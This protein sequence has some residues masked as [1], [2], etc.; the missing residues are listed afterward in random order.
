MKQLQLKRNAIIYPNRADA[1]SYINTTLADT[2]IDGEPILASYKDAD[3]SICVILGYCVVQDGNKKI[4]LIDNTEIIKKFSTKQDNL[5]S[6]TNIK[7]INGTSLLGE[8]NI[9]IVGGGGTTYNISDGLAL[10]TPNTLS[11]KINEVSEPYITCDV[12][13]ILISGINTGLENAIKSASFNANDIAT[14]ISNKAKDDAILAASL[15]ASA[16]S[17]KAK[18]DAIS[19]AALNTDNKIVENNTIILSTASNDASAKATKAKDDAILASS[20][21]TTTK[22]NQAKSELNDI[23]NVEKNRAIGVET[24]LRTDINGKLSTVTLIQD[25]TNTMHYTLMVDG[26]AKG[27]INIPVNQFLKKADYDTTTKK[28]IF[29]FNGADGEIT[30]EIDI[31]DLVDT[32]TSENGISVTDNVFTI[33]LDPLTESFLSVSSS[34]VKISGINK[35]FTDAA[36]LIATQFTNVNTVINSEIVRAT[37]AE[38]LNS[39]NLD[40]FKTEIKTY[41]DEK[42]AEVMASITAITNRLIVLETKKTVL[43]ET[44]R[45]IVPMTNAQYEVLPIKE[46]T[47]LYTLTD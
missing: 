46:E 23:I 12:N 30:S 13:G 7:S 32:Y 11:V 31:A 47:T 6:G 34:G 2:L 37:A 19:T 16:K 28:L 4:D 35:A 24:V 29:I 25:T 3:D 21:D 27:E 44:I 43:S 45:N 41:V 38:T 36:S 40:T 15:D 26:V 8:G 17:T 33:K 18:D 14:V 1:V 10:T 22:L 42:F 9:N 20:L 39:S 5:V